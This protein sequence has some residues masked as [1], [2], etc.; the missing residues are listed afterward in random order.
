MG[1]Q[2]TS[3]LSSISSWWNGLSDDVK[4]DIIVTAAG[5]AT[6]A[7]VGAAVDGWRGAAVGAP[8]AGAASYAGSHYAVPMVIR[9][10]NARKLKK[11]D[12]SV[13]DGFKKSHNPG[14]GGM[15]ALYTDTSDSDDVSKGTT[16]LHGINYRIGQ[17]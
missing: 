4:R 3:S 8:V 12:Q 1:K 2:A 17:K 6:G 15:G 5:T 10:L 14:W 7:G 13:A 9:L 11:N 16:L